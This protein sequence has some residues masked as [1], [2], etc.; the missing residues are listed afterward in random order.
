MSMTINEVRIIGFRGIG[1]DERN[2][3]EPKD[4]YRQESV[5]LKAGHVGVPLDGGKTIYGFHPTPSEWSRFATDEEGIEHL[6]QGNSLFGGVYDDTHV[7]QR[8]DALAHVTRRTAVWQTI[9]TLSSAQFARIEQELQHAV[10]LGNNFH[11]VYRF[12]DQFGGPMPIGYDNCATWPRNIGVVIPE[13]TGQLRE[14]L[15]H[16]TVHWP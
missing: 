1:F 2:Y 12:P 3:P 15:Q 5:L 7:F 8:A 13:A 14:Y 9:I 16:L 10:A 4:A 11:R 6:K